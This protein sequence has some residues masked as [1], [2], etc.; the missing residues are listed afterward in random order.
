MTDSRRFT[1]MQGFSDNLVRLFKESAG[2]EQEIR[3]Q[4]EG[5]RHE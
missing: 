1:T 4:F 2:L 5:V 3:K